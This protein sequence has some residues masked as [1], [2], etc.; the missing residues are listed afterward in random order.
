MVAG[1]CK[2]KRCRHPP[3]PL[4]TIHGIER[5]SRRTLRS[6]FIP[7]RSHT[8]PGRMRYSKPFTM[9]RSPPVPGCEGKRCGHPTLSGQT[10]IAGSVGCPSS[11]P[12]IDVRRFTPDPNTYHITIRSEA[13]DPIQLGWSVPWLRSYAVTPQIAVTLRLR[14]RR[15]I[16]RWDPPVG[17]LGELI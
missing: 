7:L 15:P 14:P 17:S 6:T 3:P 9:L 8:V 11:K 1:R 10:R 16:R 4:L 13:R 5:A 12:F 2:G